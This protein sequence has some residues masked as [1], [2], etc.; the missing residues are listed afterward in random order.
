MWRPFSARNIRT[1]RGC[2]A[3]RALIE[4]LVA[5]ARRE[6]WYRVYWMTKAGNQTARKLYDRITPVTPPFTV[7]PTV[8]SIAS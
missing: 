3:G 7:S 2:G 1:R 4:A 8:V 5:R 6:R